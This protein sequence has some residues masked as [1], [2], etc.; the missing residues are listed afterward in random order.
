M[1]RKP[2]YAD[3]ITMFDNTSRERDCLS[4]VVH[5]ILSGDGMDAQQTA[6]MPDG[7]QYI[8]SLYGATRA[9]GGVVTI[10]FQCPGQRVQVEAKYLDRLS[11]PLISEFLPLH[12]AVE[13]LRTERNRLCMEAA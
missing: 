11:Y 5:C 9:D 2:S 4:R 1:A 10:A 13:R 6:Y 7:S 8:L 12:V 3:L